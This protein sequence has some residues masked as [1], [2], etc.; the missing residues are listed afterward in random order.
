VE[1]MPNSN[2][3]E[4]PKLTNELEG[5]RIIFR[6]LRKYQHPQLD[7][8]TLS[9]LRIKPPTSLGKEGSQFFAPFNAKAFD[10]LWAKSE[11]IAMSDPEYECGWPNFSSLTNYGRAYHVALFLED[12]YGRWLDEKRMLYE[13]GPWV[14]REYV[15]LNSFSAL[16]Y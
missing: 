12:F 7:D 1:K 15:L 5:L 4:Y 6:A 2:Q 14:S 16:R 11:A 13:A 3:Q 9:K 10:E 8:G